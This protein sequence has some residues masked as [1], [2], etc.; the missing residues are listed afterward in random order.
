MRVFFVI[1][2]HSR[3]LCSSYEREIHQCAFVGANLLEF[4]LRC[5]KNGDSGTASFDARP[6]II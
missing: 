1:D 4:P 3:S 2:R 6:R 5:P